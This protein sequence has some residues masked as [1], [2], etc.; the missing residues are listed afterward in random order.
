MAGLGGIILTHGVTVRHEER[1]A[2]RQRQDARSHARRQAYVALLG[3]AT[4]MRVQV[5]VT[6]QRHWED[7]NIKL[8]TTQDHATSIG[9]CAAN[10][11]LLAPGAIAEAAQALAVTA[12]KLAADLTKSA[13]IDPRNDPTQTL[14]AGVLR[15]APDL[16]ELDKRTDE[17]G[18]VA[19]ADSA[20]GR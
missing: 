1:L 14:L 4:Q 11:A 7:M 9:L 17:F 12:S 20:D 3:A 6:S 8:M 10:V 16:R 18:R 19:A 13:D 2:E 15:A 5:H